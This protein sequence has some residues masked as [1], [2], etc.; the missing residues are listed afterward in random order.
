VQVR[1]AATL[2]YVA[3][4]VRVVGFKNSALQDC[5]RTSVTLDSL[6]TRYPDLS[7]FLHDQLS[8]AV[9][10]LQ[11]PST[12]P[13]ATLHPLLI[14]LTR[15]KP[16][17]GHAAQ[18]AQFKPLVAA[19]I[20]AQV[21]VVRKLAARAL[22]TLVVPHELALELQK[23]IMSLP[24]PQGS[25]LHPNALHGVLCAVRDFLRIN[26][27][28]CS[29]DVAA[30]ALQDVLPKLLDRSDFAD[31]TATGCPSVSAVYVDAVASAEAAFLE[32]QPALSR[33]AVLSMHKN[34]HSFREFL[35]AI[36]AR[37][38]QPHSILPMHA[39]WLKAAT[40]FLLSGWVVDALLPPLEGT[41]GGVIFEGQ[42]RAHSPSSAANYSSATANWSDETESRP[43]LVVGFTLEEVV[44]QVLSSAV[45][46]VRAEA[47]RCLSKH[48]SLLSSTS[49]AAD[50]APVGSESLAINTQPA[51]K[52]S[53]VS[54]SPRGA[55]LR[56]EEESSTAGGADGA[57]VSSKGNSCLPLQEDPALDSLLLCKGKLQAKAWE[58]ACHD[59]STKVQR[60]ALRLLVALLAHCSSG[61][62]FERSFPGLTAQKMASMLLAMLQG[63]MQHAAQRHAL[64]C[65]GSLVALLRSDAGQKISDDQLLRCA[66]CKCCV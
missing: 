44:E 39:M 57:D 56:S 35:F 19:C 24:P 41:T 30:A 29:I 59:S 14:L 65:L 60:R 4:T 32:L 38:K 36:L 16:S 47:L 26:I 15:L 52:P 58:M 45:M 1:N 17:E 42:S 49:A 31:A 7:H 62:G 10:Q 5:S 20:A 53:P 3:I 63:S 48:S 43:A 23:L 18:L 22:S 2:C 27:R 61:L 66:A 8:V 40:R 37:E 11:L 34:L 13:P 28:I 12:T 54:M 25:L 6:L 51:D 50:S 21:Y 55:K 33:A 9:S 46:E 64:V